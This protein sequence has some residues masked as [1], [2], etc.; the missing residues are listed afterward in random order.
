MQLKEKD[1]CKLFVSKFE[2]L[3]CYNQ[4][5]KKVYLYHVSN[6]QYNNMLY[7]MSLKQMGLKAGVADY[8]LLIEG[9]KCAYIEFKRNAKS[10][11]S[12]A[13]KNFSQICND[14]KIPYLLTW[15]ADEAINWIKEIIKL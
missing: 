11:V 14:L 12:E 3:R 1:I 5:S 10:K 9:G 8:C 6:E 7:T 4:F 2:M 15:D 13:Q